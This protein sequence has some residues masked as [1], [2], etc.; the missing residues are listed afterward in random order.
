MSATSALQLRSHPIHGAGVTHLAWFTAGVVIAFLIP[1]VFSSVLDLNHDLYY[2]V[3]FTA[4][5]VF[6]AT[7]AKTTRLDVVALFTRSWRWSL[8]LGVIASA[9]LVFRILSGENSTAHP[10]GL[11]F[12]F[13]IGWRGVLYGTIDALLLTAFP[14][15][16]VYTI[17]NAR[18]DSLMRRAGFALFTLALVWMITA[19]YHLGYEQFREDGVG[20]PE[21]GNTIISVPAI[22]TANPLGAVVAHA[23]MHVAAVTHAYETDLYLPPQTFADGE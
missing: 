6:L 11:Y 14:M 7:Y 17:M 23:A 5:A 2:L 20:G 21:A 3:Y 19:A 13:A 18:L 4:A 10:N 12:I 22:V 9:F 1:F 15:A 8:V 16:V